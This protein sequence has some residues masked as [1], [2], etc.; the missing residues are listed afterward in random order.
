MISNRTDSRRLLIVAL[1]TLAFPAL[2]APRLLNDMQGCQAGLDFIVSKVDAGP[3]NTSAADLADIRSALV[4]YNEAIQQQVI[5]PGLSEFTKG[6]AVK[7]AE[8]QAQ[9]DQYKKNLVAA[10]GKRYPQPDLF[11][12]YAIMVN[13]CTQQWL[14]KGG[15]VEPLRKALRLLLGDK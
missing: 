10:Y 7:S 2:S 13:N 11:A 12:D 5:T 8:L 1:A 4:A 3:P 14:P 15:D 6:D 9:V